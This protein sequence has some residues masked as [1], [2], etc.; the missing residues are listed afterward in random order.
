M[1]IQPERPLCTTPGVHRVGEPGHLPCMRHMMLA[2][3]CADA[4]CSSRERRTGEGEGESG[5]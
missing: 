3:S 2:E 4:V 1:P 5:D